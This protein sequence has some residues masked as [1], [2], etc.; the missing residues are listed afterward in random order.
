MAEGPCFYCLDKRVSIAICLDC[1]TKL[2]QAKKDLEW[3]KRAAARERA[4]YFRLS[5]E[6]LGLKA[7]I[8]R[9]QK[10]GKKR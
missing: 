2:E 5:K 4:V 9:L 3:Y 6:N 10:P 1:R 8:A 7:E